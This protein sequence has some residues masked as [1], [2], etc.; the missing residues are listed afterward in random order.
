M[1]TN[2]LTTAQVADRLGISIRSAQRNAVYAGVAIRIGR[3]IL[4]PESALPKVEKYVGN[5]KKRQRKAVTGND[6]WKLRKSVQKD[7]QS[8]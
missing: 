6:F 2:L 5:A 8:S 3:D 1:T 7:S 4:V